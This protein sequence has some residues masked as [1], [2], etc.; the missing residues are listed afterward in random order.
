MGNKYTSYIFIIYFCMEQGL[1]GS[2]VCNSWLSEKIDTYSFSVV[3]LE[4]LSGR[5]SNDMKLDPETQYLL[6]WVS[7]F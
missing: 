7:I 6:E 3:V 4:I 5:K 1:H 2:R